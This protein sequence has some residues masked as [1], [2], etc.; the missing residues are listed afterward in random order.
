MSEAPVLPDLFYQTV[1]SYQRTAI[2][3]TGLDLDIF[4]AVGSEG[5]TAEE[6][7]RRCGASVR[8]TASLADALV[9]LGFLEKDAGQYRLTAV[10]SRYLDSKSPDY[11]GGTLEFLLSEPLLSG[12]GDLTRAVR[13]GGTALPEAGTVA[14]E[15]P[16]W[17]RF[18]RAMQPAVRPIAAE[19]ARRVDPEADRPLRVLDIAAGHGLYGIA[20]AR[21]N[22]RATVTAID[23]PGVLEVAAANADSAGLGDR[24]LA[25]PGNA[26]EI[27]FGDRFDLV[28]FTNFLHHFGPDDVEQLAVKAHAALGPGGRAAILEFVPDDDRCGPP[29][30]VLFDLIMVATTPH[31]RAYTRSELEGIFASAGFSRCSMQELDSGFERLFVADR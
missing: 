31:G 23:W 15:H 22:P 21:A 25:R 3:R 29:E 20:V 27:D 30:A 7:A 11:L 2:L 28:F 13:R 14:P 1:G 26:L 9:V 10:S 12:F 18:A 16:V 24:Y 5:A 8:G 6:L 19:L 4:S 17:V